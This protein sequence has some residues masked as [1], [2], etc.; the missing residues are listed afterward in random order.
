MDVDRFIQGLQA[1]T[2]RPTRVINGEDASG[3]HSFCDFSNY[4]CH[5]HI[6][7]DD[8]DCEVV[9]RAHILD[10]DR[11]FLGFLDNFTVAMLRHYAEAEGKRI[12]VPRRTYSGG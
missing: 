4:R 5:V 1:G 12:G 7:Y 6:H 11:N 3:P 10:H 2:I 9:G 8:S